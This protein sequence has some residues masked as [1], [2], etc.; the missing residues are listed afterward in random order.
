VGKR[1]LAQQSLLDQL[2]AVEKRIEFFVA[3]KC[4]R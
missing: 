4:P 2:D 3:S 1:V